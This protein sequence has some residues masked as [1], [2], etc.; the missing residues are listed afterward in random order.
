VP[1][2]DSGI[3]S[4]T[5]Y[6]MSVVAPTSP[7][8]SGRLLAR[9]TIW[10]LLGQLLP[11][12]VAVV[13]I[14]PLV[15]G[16]G[17]A[18]FGVLSLA[19]IVVGYFS[20]FEL[21]IGRALT[22]LVADKLGANEEHSIPP[23]AWTSLLL[24]FLLGALGGLVAFTISPWLVHGA[25]KVPLELQAETLRGFYL[26]ALSIPIV[27]LTSGLRS[28]LEAQQ[29]FRILNL[30][31]IP[32]SIF[33]F[34]GPLLVLPFSH[35]L[36]P[37]IGILVAGR[38]IGLAA[39]LLACFH[40]M[41]ALRHNFVLRRSTVMPVVKFGG[42]LTVT[43]IVGPFLLY[44]DRFLVGALLSVTAVAYYTAPCDMVMRLTIISGAVAGVLF[45]AFAVSLMQDPDRT[46]SL[47]SRGVKYV[48]LSLFP[49]VL[50][51][52]TFAPEGLRLWLGPAFAQNSSSVLRWLAAGVFII[53]LATVPYVLIQGAGRPDITAK[54]HVAELPVYSAALWL[55]TMKFGIEGTA[56]AWTGRVILD[57]VFLFSYS[58][59]LVAQSPRFLAK[60]GIT[61]AGGLAVLYLASLPASLVIRAAFLGA[62][63]LV[64]GVAGWFWALGPGE[65]VFLV[66]TRTE[67]QVKVHTN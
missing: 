38:T 39:H 14:P 23:L 7:L 35:S 53:S 66:G 29:R 57:A 33:S 4:A 36:V 60:L 41:P 54:L 49:I 2:A 13:A 28:I 48:F 37:V 1:K 27:I 32:M 44:M 59:R 51:I 11:M 46:G 65:R 62:S 19:W 15:R 42:W 17:V 45:P 56:I 64:F 43:N 40:A 55:L 22:K 67:A 61:V 20:L 9:N 50:V 18:R 52:V 58:Q 47:L 63:L 5:Q 12:A 26:L 6:F 30:I 16:L 24:M 10:N 34:A 21:G 25:L 31:R 3:G 8:T